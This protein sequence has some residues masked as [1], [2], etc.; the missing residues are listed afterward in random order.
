MADGDEIEM[1]AGF[2]HQASDPTAKTP[3]SVR[4]I[5]LPPA[6][7]AL[8]TFSRIDYDDAFLVEIGQAQDL[9]SEQWARAILE[10]APVSTRN[11]LS[12]GWAALGLR[13]GSTRSDRFVLGWEIRRRTPDVTLLGA[14]GRLGISGE[15]LFERQPHTLLFATFVRQE[16]RIARGLWDRIAPTHRKV[17]QD[18]LEQAS[19]RE[20]LV[21]PHPVLAQD[22]LGLQRQTG[23]RT[24]VP[25]RNGQRLGHDVR[26]GCAIQARLRA[27]R[28]TLDRK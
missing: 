15:L 12:R 23:T 6:A 20:G 21:S 3:G 13:L 11:K 16:N 18:L 4:Q 9:T 25:V 10:G 7:R 28:E 27:W 19:A 17:V 1:T 14:R 5:A 22:G 8:S 26:L 2:G 24:G